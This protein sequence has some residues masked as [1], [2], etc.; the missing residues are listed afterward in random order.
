M[1]AKRST[2]SL[3]AIRERFALQMDGSRQ[4]LRARRISPLTA[5]ERLENRPGFLRL[6]ALSATKSD[7]R[8][9]D[10]LIEFGP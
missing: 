2:D 4:T 10:G 5:L 8:R 3:A 1:Q 6:P 7:P 9:R